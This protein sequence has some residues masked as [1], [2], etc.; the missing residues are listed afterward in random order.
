MPNYRRHYLA[1]PV[2]VTVVTHGREPWIK[3]EQAETVLA[4]MRAVKIKY[5]FRHL[6]H[7]VLPDHL[8]WLFETTDENDFSRQVTALKREVTWRL[9]EQ[10]LAGPFWQDRFYDHLVRDEADFQAH[11]DYIHF[12]PVKHG[13]CARAMDWPHSSFQSWLERGAYEA[14]WGALEPVNLAGMDME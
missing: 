5:P 4:A 2:F 14:D 7:A 6:A 10:G 1:L 11:L 9:K 8:H 3:G 12:N 13:H